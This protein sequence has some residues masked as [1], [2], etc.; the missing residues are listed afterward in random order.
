MIDKWYDANTDI[1][2]TWML[3]L[4]LSGDH[5]I[6]SFLKFGFLQGNIDEETSCQLIDRFEDWGGYFIDTA[7]FYGPKLSES[8]VG[9]WLQK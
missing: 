5:V 3:T 6:V 1:I 9:N 8:I 2:S 4:A 7:D